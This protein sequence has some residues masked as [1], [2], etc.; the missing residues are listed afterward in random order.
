MGE[1]QGRT[2]T[3]GSLARAARLRERE[4]LARVDQVWPDSLPSREV[5]GLPPWAAEAIRPGRTSRAL[6]KAAAALDQVL[7]GWTEQAVEV[8]ARQLLREPDS[9]VERACALLAHRP[10]RHPEPL[11]CLLG[12]PPYRPEAHLLLLLALGGTDT[13]A[14]RAA[15]REELLRC[16]NSPALAGSRAAWFA[17]ARALQGQWLTFQEFREALTAGRALAAA[18]GGRGHRTPSEAGYRPA[19]E[20]LGLWTD[21]TFAKWYRQVVYEVSTQPDVALSFAAS[22]WITD[23]PGEDYLLEALQLLE[24]DPDSW[25]P[26]HLLR[27]S[28]G[29]SPADPALPE[30]LNRFS[31]RTLCLLSL[32]RPELSAA[33]ARVWLN[34]EHE[35]VIRWLTTATPATQL[36]LNWADTILRP[37]V[38]VFGGDLTLAVGALCAIEPPPDFAPEL[39]PAARRHTFHQQRFGPAATRAVENLLYVLALSDA[40]FTLVCEQASKGRPTAVRAL[41]LRPDRAEQTAPLLF[42]LAR[43]GARPARQAA[44][45]T[46]ALLAARSGLPDLARLEKRV[47]LAAAWSEEEGGGKLARVWWEVAGYHVRLA[48]LGGEVKLHVY[49]GAKRLAALPAR[50]RRDPAYAEIRRTRDD[51]ARRYRY[52]RRRFEQAMT[53]GRD[54]PGREFAVLL[55]SPVVRSL[56]SRLMLL[57]DGVPYH[58]SPEDPLEEGEPPRELTSAARITIAHPVALHRAGCLEE[59]QQQVIETHLAQPFKQAFREIYLLGEEEGERTHC[60]R[61]AG[62]SLHAR[63]AFALLRQQGYNPKQGEAV[64]EWPDGTSA[65]LVWAGAEEA[66]G[67]LLAQDDPERPVTSGHIWFSRDGLILRLAQVSPILFSETLRDADLTVSLAPYGELGFTSEETRRLRATLVRYLARTA[68]LTTIYLSEDYAHALVEG[69]RAMYRVH[70]GSGSVLLD[71]SR[72]HLHV[73]P[74]VLASVEALLAESMDRGTAHIV[75][76]IL[77]LSQDDQITDPHFLRQLGD[78]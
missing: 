3:R 34:E 66:A 18:S 55:A 68:G 77:T 46:L 22:G 26:L 67:K 65:H 63:R 61:F 73:G 36:D 20:R 52:F 75:S 19:L 47:D 37:W 41:A 30:K 7:P 23:F 25:W 51:L 16:A 48:V 43:K 50:L 11:V 4:L 31:R 6:Q 29:V 27:W 45:D 53:E 78:P 40:N 15:V 2:A 60:A 72:R 32:V 71:K 57:V 74:D 70:L 28:S 24:R 12:A 1:G 44:Q 14:V 21:P 64:K 38:E 49:S 69:R 5:A 39:P 56:V 58:W 8:V 10:L 9:G 76:L 59:W 17:F 13:A 33:V 42:S 35:E 54:Y 62:L